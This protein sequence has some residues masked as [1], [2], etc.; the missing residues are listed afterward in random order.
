MDAP[1]DSLSLFSPVVAR[2]FRSH[3]GEPT[4]V[5]VRAWPRIAAGEHT[6][7]TAPTGSGKT[8]TAFLWAI[9]R[10]LRREWPAGQTSV[11][12]VS[13]LKA[14]NNDIQRNLLRPLAELERLYGATGDVFPAIHVMTR[15]GD[16]PQAARR[17]MLKHP[18]EILITTPE[19][20]NIL[21]SSRGGRQVLG[22]L[23][24]VILDEIHAVLGSKRGTH[25]I[26]AVERLVRLSGEFQRVSLSATVRPPETV[27]RFVGGYELT[28]DVYAARPVSIVHS[29]QRKATQVE[30][31]FPAEAIDVEDSDSLWR[32]LVVEFKRI[33]QRNRSTLVFVRTRRLCEQLTRMINEGEEQPLAYAHHGS[34]S[35]DIRLEVERRL[36]HGEL[37]AIVATNSL[38]LGI[39]IGELDE[40]VLVQAPASISS[41]VQRIGRAGHGVGE[42]SRATVFPTHALDFLETAVLVRGVLDRDIEPAR[43]VTCPLDVLAQV[44]VSMVGAE[45]WSIDGLFAF[46]RTCSPYHDLSRRQFDTV[47]SMLAGRYEGTRIRD[48]KP[49]VSVDAIDSTVSARQSALMA[50]YTSGGTIPDRGY[51]RLR[52][53]HTGATI[54]ELD[55][56]FVWE[57][58]IGQRMTLGTQAWRIEGITHNDVF[59]VPGGATGAAA[60]FWRAERQSRDFHFSE[61]IG[62]FLEAASTQLDDPGYADQLR[63]RHC[64]DATSAERLAGFLRRQREATGCDIPHRHHLVVEHIES[65]PG[66]QREGSQV[67]LHTLWGGRVNRPF[68]LALQAAWRERFGDDVEAFAGD[69]C[70]YILEPKEVSGAEI[71]SLVTCGNVETLLRRTLEGSGFFGARFRE[72]AGRALLLSR[73]HKNQRMPLWLSRLKSMKLLESVMELEDFPVLLEAWRTCLQD[74]FDMQSLRGMLAEIESGTIRWSETVRAAP[75]PLAR[76]LSWGQINTYM[77]RDDTPGRGVASRLREDLLREAVFSSGLRPTVPA[78]AVAEFLARRQRLHPG[79][80]PH[81]PADLLDWVKERLAIPHPEWQELLR[82]IERDH[83]LDPATQLVEPIA[84]KL[85]RIEPPGARGAL[86]LALETAVGIAA[87]LWPEATTVQLATGSSMTL[88]AGTDREEDEELLTSVLGEWL[89]FYGPVQPEFVHSTLGLEPAR[90]S[91]AL[92]DLVETRELVAGRL[93]ADGPG[94]DVCDSRNFEALL[95]LA[96]ARAAPSFEPLDITRLPLFLAHIQGLTCPGEDVPDLEARVEQLTGHEARADLWEAEILPSRVK[97]YRTMWLD[98]L[99]HERNMTWLGTA[100]GRL[101]FCSEPDLDLV[102]PPPSEP[103]D[104]D[105]TA[106]LF[107]HPAGRYP[108]ATLLEHSGGEAPE[109]SARLWDAVWHGRLTNDS[110]AAMRRGLQNHFKAAAPPTP[111]TPLGHRRH[112]RPGRTSFARWKAALPFTGNWYLVPAPEPETDPIEAEE[113]TRERVRILL[114]RYGVLFRQLLDREIPAF[115]W[116]SVFRSLRLMEL[117]GEVVSGCFFHGVP[118]LQFVSHQA[119]QLLRSKLP[120]QR[121]YWMNATDPASP[122]GMQIDGLREGLPKRVPSTHLVY[123]GA[124]LVLVSLRNG[125]ELRFGVE[126]GDRRMADILAPVRHLLGREFRPLR[127]IAVETIND[128]PAPRSEYVDM[129]RLH[130]QVS[131]DH[132]SVLLYRKTVG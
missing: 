12:Y 8:L 101:L 34:L 131:V 6:L 71:L 11:L 90:L 121:V 91:P 113:R 28:G 108:F 128:Q 33:I 102:R 62:Q 110:F 127:S 95:R 105:E 21:L 14:L 39:D 9:D 83:G 70:I 27:A 122:C 56:E 72:C 103:D 118:G 130:F 37:R 4:D 132:R 5:Q 78:A 87:D 81:T 26:T 57:A 129:L 115:R 82:A 67:V 36:K 47:L 54:G 55:E 97:S 107:P 98:S 7:I 94:D 88:P 92:E 46:I 106:T 43:P 3:V 69:D 1:N 48:L 22:G 17:R 86:I 18:P 52:H 13:P 25:L 60:P 65:G 16:T 61:R 93:V 125:K 117:G 38:E 109:L 79:Y 30:V 53:K 74:E 29:R 77:Y 124:E 76:S 19:S 51:F 15:S 10:L 104:R 20:L 40:V 75:S 114:D 50:L 2:W 64:L 58:T 120:E 31:R 73:R 44:L 89:Q 23:R 99:V 35:R 32:A 41:A 119:L 126:P 96:R 123:C 63:R 85:V 42:V 59:V 100:K 80:A 45:T 111:A 24:T 49:R 68:A 116:A 66:G 112:R 84:S